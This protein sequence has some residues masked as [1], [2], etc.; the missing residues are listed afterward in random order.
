MRRLRAVPL[1]VLAA[2][3]LT[4]ACGDGEGSRPAPAP[5]NRIVFGART[6]EGEHGLYLVAPDGSAL[7]RLSPEANAVLF[8]RIS[9]TRD[10]IAYLVAGGATEQPG[11]L[12]VY[13]LTTRSAT[14]IFNQARPSAGPAFDWSPD[15]ERIAFIDSAGQLRVIDVTEREL[16]EL[17]PIRGT[18]PA[19]APDGETIALVTGAGREVSL[20]EPSGEER[21][22]LFRSGGAVTGLAWSSSGDRLAVETTSQG[23]YPP[24]TVLL[25][26][27]TGGGVATLANATNVAWS[28]KGTLVAYSAPP[29][30]QRRNREIYVASGSEDREA[31]TET[32]TIDRWPT[33]AP[34]GERLAYLSQVDAKTAFLCLARLE[35]PERDCLDL[36]DLIPGAPHWR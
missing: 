8:P 32:V 14:T 25:L 5:L 22:T 21:R 9:P 26:N 30:G 35:P 11:L 2:L 12:R 10:R 34:D 24:T 15:G 17:S 16:I 28:P 7:E 23:E 4:T 1:L 13:D 36:G 27:I 18:Q 29:R 3:A 33:W 6:P 20:I 19:W 31:L